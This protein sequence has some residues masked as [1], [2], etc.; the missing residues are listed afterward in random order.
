M[1]LDGPPSSSLQ[2]PKIGGPER[3]GSTAIVPKGPLGQVPKVWYGRRPG[4]KPG[5]KQ[6]PGQLVR[7]Q[8]DE[9]AAQAGD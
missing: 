6:P 4:Q 7:A 1:E 3:T 2:L 8:Y 5:Y 9:I